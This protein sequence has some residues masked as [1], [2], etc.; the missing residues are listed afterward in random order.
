M[1]EM[2]LVIKDSKNNRA[3]GEDDIPYEFIKELIKPLLKDGKDP[4]QTTSYRPHNFL[5]ACMG[6]L[7]E[8]M[9]AD[10]L[11][12]VLE[13]CNL[14]NNSQAGFR[15]N[16]CTR[17]TRSSNLSKKL[18]INFTLSSA[19]TRTITAFFDYEKAFNEVWRDVLFTRCWRWGFL[20]SSLDMSGGR[21]ACVNGIRIAPTLHPQ[22]SSSTRIIHFPSSVPNLHEWH[23]CWSQPRHRSE[24]LRRWHCS[25]YERWKGE[26]KQSHINARWNQ[27]NPQ[28]GR[29]MEVGIKEGKT[30]AMALASSRKDTA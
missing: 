17:P 22:W 27:Q 2:Q 7:L 19:N 3:S 29:S 11:I 24:S 10:K 26:R 15:P 12:Y 30:K 5:T 21:K 8:K 1:A 23:R 13:N 4:K 25:L 6:K 9:V 16:R 14:L 28:M 18:L 20:P